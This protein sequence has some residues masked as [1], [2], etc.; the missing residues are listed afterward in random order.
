[1]FSHKI[2]YLNNGLGTIKHGIG[3]P[4]TTI[5]WNVSNSNQSITMEYSP[6]TDRYNSSEIQKHFSDDKVFEFCSGLKASNITWG[7]G[8]EE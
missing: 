5:A 6:I 3:I 8:V 2:H 7:V 4:D 1:M